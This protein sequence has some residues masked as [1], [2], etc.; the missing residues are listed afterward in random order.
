MKKLVLS[1]ALALGGFSSQAQ[2]VVAGVSPAA[3]QGN[4]EFTTQAN[5]GQWPGETDDATWGAW[6]GGLDFNTPGDFIQDTLMLVEDGTPGTNLQGNPISQEGCNPLTNDLTGK[7]AVIYR[8]TCS[9]VSKIKNA[10]DAGAVAAI[11]VNREDELLGMLGDATDGINVNIPAVFVSNVTGAALISEMANGPVVMFI[12]NKLGAF[13]NDAGAVKGEFLVNQFGGSHSSVYDGM[14]PGIQVYNYGTSDQTALTVNASIDGPSGNVYTEDIGPL[15]MSAGD[16][17]FIFPG[18]TD[19]FTPWALG[20]GN[21][22]NGNYTLTYTID[23]GGPDDF[24]FDNVYSQDFTIQD[25]VISSSRVDASN[26]PIANSYPSNST[27][28]YEACMVFQDPNA[29]SLAVRGIYFVPHTDTSVNNLAGA[30]IFVNAYQ[31][32]DGWVD[33]DDPNYDFTPATT[34]AYNNLNLVAFATH[35]PASN[36]DVDDVAYADF[37]M[38]NYFQLIDNQRYLFC[39]QTFESTT[40]S[41]GYD[42]SFDHGA[43]YSIFSQP[44]S[45]L[46][47]DGSWYT[48]GWNSATAPSLALRTFDPAELG[49]E[50]TEMLEGKAFPNPANN[51]VTIS[52][53]ASGAAAL[54]ATDV[55]GKVAINTTIT[56][57]NGTT[58]V[59]ISSLESGVYIFNVTMENGESTQFNVVKN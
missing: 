44:I 46:H 37:G 39:L 14:T 16:T 35:Y 4:Y 1:V 19:S 21:Y 11:I 26:M 40:I 51:M 38:G 22:E 10:Q 57:E 52:V 2:V 43:N 48:A 53:G 47:T 15:N 32:D 28:Q 25:D 41:F 27:T 49:L 50:S 8:N 6:N 36:D 17:A 30:E 29:S 55:A 5:C 9:F 42:N 12:G 33:L 3:I 13:A 7:I 45:P 23:L 18:N 54:T 34:D 59:D 24:A 20:V 56:L 58:S 31:W